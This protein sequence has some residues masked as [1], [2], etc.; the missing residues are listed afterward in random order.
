MFL[1]CLWVYFS[2]CASSS[3]I[4]RVLENPAPGKDE[5]TSFAGRR[6]W[7]GQDGSR[8]PLTPEDRQAE[9]RGE[10]PGPPA[11][12]VEGDPG[13]WLPSESPGGT[14]GSQSFPEKTSKLKMTKMRSMTSL[15][16]F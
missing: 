14:W 7:G 12:R 5:C 8:K 10:I 11:G 3:F 9:F 13:A 4:P 6:G 16:Y 2:L 15:E 1:K